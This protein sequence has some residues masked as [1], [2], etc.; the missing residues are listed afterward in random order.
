MNLQI[1]IYTLILFILAF[2]AITMN[3]DYHKSPYNILKIGTKIILFISAISIIILYFLPKIHIKPIIN[4]EVGTAF[5]L[6][7]VMF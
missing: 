4:P 6:A 1:V 2:I 5:E 7:N 3:D